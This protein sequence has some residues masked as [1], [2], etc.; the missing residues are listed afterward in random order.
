MLL[1]A[2]GDKAAYTIHLTYP[3]ADID[4]ERKKDWR[5]SRR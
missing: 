4:V 3:A 5:R 1:E 2:R